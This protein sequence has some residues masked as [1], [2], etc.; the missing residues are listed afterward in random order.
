M[1]TLLLLALAAGLFAADQVP[2][3]GTTWKFRSGKVLEGNPPGSALRFKPG[4]V[5]TIPPVNTN[6]TRS[7]PR[8]EPA[9]VVK[10]SVS[11]DGQ[12]LTWEGQGTDAKGKMFRF[13]QTWDKQ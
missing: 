5:W 13:V 4:E 3:A 12:V 11:P 6:P 2:S 8:Q 10:F 1:R 7:E 9:V